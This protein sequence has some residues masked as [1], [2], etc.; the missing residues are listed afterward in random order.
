MAAG[1]TFKVTRRPVGIDPD[2]DHAHAAARQQPLDPVPTERVAG[3]VR[4]P[5]GLVQ[6]I[7]RLHVRAAFEERILAIGLEQCQH[8]RPHDR[9]VGRRPFDE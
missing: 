4:M 2:V 6:E 9:I 1:S 5:A 8:L 7:D 3:R